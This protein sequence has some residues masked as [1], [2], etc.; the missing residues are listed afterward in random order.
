MAMM[1]KPEGVLWSDDQ[2]RAIADGGSDI[3]VAAAAGSGKTAVLVE[4]IIR[5]IA[6]E[7]SGFSV[8]RLL[9]ATFT[10]AAASEMR[11]RI[12]EALEKELDRDPDN[13]HLRRQL[14]LLGRASITTLHSFC[15]EV[16]R[17]HYQQIPIDPGFR[18]L[19]EHEAEMMRQELLEELVEEKYGEAGEDG[20]FVQLADWFGGER[21]DD[22]LHALIQRLH[23]FSRSHPWP[24][25]WL[26]ETA[27]A[28]TLPDTGSLEK[29]AW[30]RS[31][32][33]ETQLTLAGAA[34]MLSQGIDAALAPGGPAPYADTL[35]EELDMVLGLLEDAENRSWGEL[36][37]AFA[38]AAFGKLKPVKKDSVDPQVQE[39][40]KALR[41]GAK[42]S[43]AD[44]RDSLFGRPP[45]RYL[46]ELHA[47]APLMSE[48]AETVIE[49][50]RRF[51]AEKAGRGLVDFGDLEHYCL[52]ILRHEHSGYGE[53]YPS[54]AAMEYRGR[55]DEVLLDEYQDTN[56]VQEEIVRLISRD[57]P[58]NRF[59]VGD[60]KQSIYRFRL[61]EPG[62]FLAKYL[63]YGKAGGEEA[64]DG[65]EEGG[66]GEAGLQGEGAGD[67]GRV[68]DLARNFR[69]RREVVHAVNTVFRQVMNRTVAEIGYDSRA[70][71][72]YG[73]HFPDEGDNGGIVYTP[74]VLL[75]DRTGEGAV[76]DAET[77][78][79]EPVRENDAAEAETA[80]LEG[81]AIAKRILAL[82]GMNGGNP[83]HIYD[84]HQRRMRPVAYGDIVV[85]LRS[86]RL[87]TPVIVEELRLHGIPAQGDQSSGY[88]GATEVEIA[89]ALLKVIDN[90][91]QDIPL[92]A[93]LRSPVV[94]LTEEELA[95]VRLCA[96]GPF[97]E[98]LMA[99]VDGRVEHNALDRPDNKVDPAAGGRGDDAGDAGDVSGM[100]NTG[101]P[102]DSGYAGEP[103]PEVPAGLRRR[104][105]AFI[106]MLEGW[107]NEAARGSLGR[108]IWRVYTESGYLDWVAG[109][110]GG[111][112]RQNNL[113]A[114]YDRAVQFEKD[115][116]ARGLFRFLV[117]LSRLRENGGDLGA[118]GGESE[119][120]GGVQIMTIHKS[121]GLEFPVVFIA[122][123]SKGFN[124]QDLH[125][126]LLTHK[127]LGFGP[128]YLERDTRVGYPTLPHLAIGRRSRMELLAE[129]MRVLYVALTRPRDKMILVGTVRDLARQAAGWASVQDSEEL[130]LPAH[131][132]ARG[133]SY[134]DWIGPALI[135]HPSAAVL[136][137]LAGREG[138]SSSVLHGDRSSWS[139]SALA[140]SDL[141]AG[142]SA[143]L[144]GDGAEDERAALLAAVRAGKPVPRT[145][146]QDPSEPAGKLGW[147]YPYE[148][149]SR[150]PAKTSVTELKSLIALEE[151]PSYDL[152]E[153]EAGDREEGGGFAGAVAAARSNSGRSD[154]L[155]LRRPKFIEQRGLTPAERGTAYHAV[156][157]HVPLDRG[158]DEEEI[159]LTLARLE[160]LA[161]LT[162]EQAQ[163]VEPERIG[164][165]LAGPLGTRLRAAEWKRREM[166]FSYMVPATEAYRGLDGLGEAAA[167][168]EEKP[169]SGI[170]GTAPASG[171]AGEHSNRRDPHMPPVL[172]QGV[173][174]ALFRSE[175]GKLALLDYKTDAVLDHAGGIKVLT[176]KYRFQ[177]ELY[178][179]AL[180]DI[181]GERVSELWLY[182]FD[183][184]HAVRL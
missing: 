10:K 28:F 165:F 24:E 76:P 101:G 22:A 29:T 18:I 99:A 164:A 116:S 40:V 48:L 137:K 55:F 43:V 73:A 110:P 130:V 169:R 122:G 148:A 49:F 103:A 19:N 180:G 64:H 106:N 163:A 71:L 177:L 111:I 11:Q 8:D 54:D 128:R 13:A 138:T 127:E 3:L 25:E 45:E 173:I 113:K 95:L 104:L 98:A 145:G 93:T 51:E 7:D 12:R 139:I 184:D 36:H 156:M 91:R 58:G 131:L 88:F 115:T 5:K 94:G 90:P 171:H 162:P 126:P 114:L 183:G 135:R 21:T 92:A 78:E 136:R 53:S 20:L 147:K 118:A 26:R 41:E 146:E 153:H 9:V 15:L 44:L 149:A 77:A 47:A 179:A 154:S 66:S 117:F 74:E 62:L 174:D 52:R 57:S 35:R 69:S 123:I 166:P 2:W 109:L 107:R 30:V 34:D 151:R 176:D 81:R 1:P 85:L 150:L 46:E 155:R 124:R 160:R 142:L 27:A 67:S 50:G 133:R 140:A 33:E 42:K 84:K 170:P 65:L 125:A 72:A 86:A 59:M 172:I 157:Q 97:Y 121:K 61:A 75:I 63:S 79:G 168:L 144:A 39:A 31:L 89:L 178:A 143:G 158:P 167:A 108:L 100:G 17:R 96:K 6:S 112:Q 181:L 37:G 141:T 82:T 80:Q 159:R 68:I 4:R 120:G 83:L 14:A 70:E 161:I 60:M 152:L 105:A 87:W 38:A 102:S 182:F 23:D 134:L 56:S 175:D 119:A 129:E 132:L 32:L 16:I